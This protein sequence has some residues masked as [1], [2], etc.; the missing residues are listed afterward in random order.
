MHNSQGGPTHL[1][2]TGLDLSL[3]GCVTLAKSLPLFRLCFPI[4]RII[5]TVAS[6]SDTCLSFQVTS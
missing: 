2:K 1:V 3:T 5:F 4:Y 6:S